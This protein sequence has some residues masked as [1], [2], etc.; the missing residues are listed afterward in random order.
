MY[1]IYNASMGFLLY[2]TQNCQF[3]I[4]QIVFFEQIVKYLTPQYFTYSASLMGY[5]YLAD[6]RSPDCGSTDHM[7]FMLDCNQNDVTDRLYHCNSLQLLI[8]TSQNKKH[9]Y[10]SLLPYFVQ[11]K[12]IDRCNATPI[13][14]WG[15]CVETA[16]IEFDM[17]TC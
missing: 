13:T 5:L 8:V 17:Q 3:K 6:H 14:N 10:Y 11:W 1:A 16:R 9:S 2:S 4:L 15:R 12:W 7:I